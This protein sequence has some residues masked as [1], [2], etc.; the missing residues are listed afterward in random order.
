ME[1]SPRIGMLLL[2]SQLAIILLSVC[3]RHKDGR[4][5]QNVPKCGNFAQTSRFGR[6]SVIHWSCKSWMCSTGS[7]RQQ[8][9]CDGE[10]NCSRSWSTPN[11]KIPKTSQL[12]ATTWEVTLENVL[13]AL[14][15]WRTRPT[16]QSS[17]FSLTWTITKSRQK[18]WKFLEN[19]QRLTCRLWRNA[20][21]WKEVE[22]RTYF[23]QLISW[24]E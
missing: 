24:P 11:R 19:C 13:N 5:T 15:K 8:Q 17:P 18:I 7:T 3:W 1:G 12:E 10:T 16:S 14:A 2:S 20:Y 9:N 21:I 6:P 23:G 4:K 22:D